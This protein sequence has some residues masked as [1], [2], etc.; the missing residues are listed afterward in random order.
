M[1]PIVMLDPGHGGKDPG[2]VGPT[3]L[4]EKDVV[5]SV[6]QLTKAILVSAGVEVFMTRTGDT[7][8]ELA[9]RARNANEVSADLFLSVHCNSAKSPARGFEV[10]TTRGQTRADPLATSLFLAFGIEF[11]DAIKRL[12]PSDGDPD[13]ETSFA[14]LRLTNMP[15]ALFELEF[16][17][18]ASGEAFLRDARNQARCAKA[19]AAGILDHLGI[20]PVRTITPLGAEDEITA[21][22]RL[23]AQQAAL[24]SQLVDAI[25]RMEG[26]A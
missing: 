24:H 19:L 23:L 5:L 11:P 21:I 2:A 4:K 6:C 15:A 17:H 26:E 13:K 3:G 20:A 25:N 7:F 14:V 10:F 12:D 9:V 1:K 22:R 8:P 16:I 18:D